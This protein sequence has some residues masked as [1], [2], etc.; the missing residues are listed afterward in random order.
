VR[1]LV[2]KTFMKSGEDIQDGMDISLC[3]VNKKTNEVQW[4]GANNPLWYFEN[5]ELKE[6]KADKQPIGKYDYSHPFTSHLLT[7]PI[8][9]NLYLFTD[10]YSDQ[11]NQ[12][13]K[14]MTKKRFRDQIIAVQANHMKDQKQILSSYFENWKGNN[15]QID[16]I[17][18]I[19]IRI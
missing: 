5:Q 6:V 16:D 7:L 15:D 19:G 18:I 8:G 10:G 17:C 4:S 12:E 1:D 13:E 11:F 9:T 14:K 2:L 3:R